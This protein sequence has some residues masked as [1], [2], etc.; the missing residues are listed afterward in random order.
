MTVRSRND[1]PAEAKP[2]QSTAGS[3]TMLRSMLVVL[4]GSP[5]SEPVIALAFEWARRFGARLLGLG[6]LDAPSIERG[7]P[8]PMGAYAYKKHRDEIRMD[9]AHRRVVRLLTEFRARCAAARV[10]ATTVEDIGDPPEQIL[11]EAQR[12]DVVLLAC[13]SRFGLETDDHRGRTLAHVIRGLPRPV[14]VVPPEPRDGR[15]IVV[16]YGGGRE[17]ASTLQTFVLLG[18]DAGQEVDLVT[19]HRDSAE[20][21]AIARRGGDFLTAHGV[22]HRLH[23]IASP[24]APAGVILDIV[25][26]RR[27]RLL[28]MGAHATH[29]VRDLFVTSVTRAVLRACPVPVVV[30][31]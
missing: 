31:V 4:D 24:E 1:S 8:V 25:E 10:D 29:P 20:A 7:E 16:A 19:V 30:G 14:V 17:A 5:S 3:V 13:E 21:S 12:C 23:P 11:R 6:V 27:P 15:G 28:V 26:R 2:V 9:E 18:L 22:A